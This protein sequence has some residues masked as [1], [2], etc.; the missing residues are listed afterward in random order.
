MTLGCL[1][2]IACVG[3]LL[4]FPLSMHLPHYSVAQHPLCPLP[5]A[6]QL[7]GDSPSAFR[8]H[9]WRGTPPLDHRRTDSATQI[10]A[11]WRRLCLSFSVTYTMF[12]EDLT[13]ILTHTKHLHPVTFHSHFPPPTPLH[14]IAIY[15][16]A[17]YC[18]PAC[19]PGLVP[20]VA[21]YSA[22]LH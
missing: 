21:K 4:P 14:L 13:C 15:I 16:F 19:T 18:L 17:I 6:T 7:E 9:N 12:Q 8:P 3:I 10:G 11:L 22:T 1:F 20:T 2:V 5:Q